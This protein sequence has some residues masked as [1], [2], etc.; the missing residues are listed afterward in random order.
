MRITAEQ[1]RSAY[2]QIYARDSSR[3]QNEGLIGVRYRLPKCFGL[4]RERY[5]GCGPL[6]VLEV[7]CGT[8]EIGR[9]LLESGLA[10]E[11]YVGI[12]Y[13]GPAVERGRAAGFDCRQMDAQELDFPDDSFDLVFCFDVMHHV[14][15]P[16]RMAREMVRV[17]RRHFFLCEANGLSP[18]RKLGELNALARSLGERSYLPRT[19]RRFF[20]ADQV[21]A[22]EI[23]PFYVLV[24]PG[25]PEGLI[26]LVVRS[27]EFLERVPVVRWLGQSLMIA[28]RKRTA[29]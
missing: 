7:G 28:G 14:D 29:A 23:K 25:V 20:P 12:D 8:G 6:R 17:T 19:Y 15:R 3:L 22:I 16:E 27:S 10:V 21:A 1:M 26:P 24:P 2:D 13:S 5:S 4:L 11:N 18:V 9:M